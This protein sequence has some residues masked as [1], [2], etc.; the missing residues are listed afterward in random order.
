MIHTK[1]SVLRDYSFDTGKKWAFC[2]GVHHAISNDGC[3]NLL[4]FISGC[5]MGIDAY[6]RTS[7]NENETNDGPLG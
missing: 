5:C 7:L 6:E 1:L 2:L 4:Q 3:H